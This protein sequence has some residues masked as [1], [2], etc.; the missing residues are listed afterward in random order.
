MT[1]CIS[2]PGA[3]EVRSGQ[4]LEL[5]AQARVWRVRQGLVGL[6]APA[7]AQG[8]GSAEALVRPGELLGMMN[9]LGTPQAVAVRAVTDAVIEELQPQL[10]D[11]AALLG[12]AYAQ[13]RRQHRQ[14]RL[15]QKGPVADRVR[16]LLLLLTDQD[17]DQNDTLAIHLPSLA[18]MA[19][20]IDSTEESVCRVL[21]RLRDLR[22]LEAAALQGGQRIVQDLRSVKPPP[23]MTNSSK[24]VVRAFAGSH[25]TAS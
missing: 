22:V 14:L 8:E 4:R 17:S 2:I 5:G 24:A 12:A 21:A 20:C 10:H 6:V 19:W 23:G 3:I 7:H 18:V 16:E 25:C 9:L 1:S 11:P 15:L 13:A